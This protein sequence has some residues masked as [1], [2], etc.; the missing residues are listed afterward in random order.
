MM[1]ERDETLQERETLEERRLRE[2]RAYRNRKLHTIRMNPFSAISQQL[3]HA[4]WNLGHTETPKNVNKG[5]A[6]EN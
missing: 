6:G 3:M 2:V 4:A 5:E 1:S